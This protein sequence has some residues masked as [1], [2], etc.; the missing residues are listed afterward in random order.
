MKTFFFIYLRLKSSNTTIT[1]YYIKTL[2]INKLETNKPTLKMKF[3]FF[4]KNE[5]HF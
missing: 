1:P 4:K 5:L 2:E 3:Y